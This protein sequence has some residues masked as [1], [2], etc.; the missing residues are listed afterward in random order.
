MKF[1]E[2]A[3]SDFQTDST[4]N[5]IRRK[6]ASGLPRLPQAT[7]QYL[8]QKVPIVQWLPQYHP[9]WLL[10]DFIAGMTIGVMMIPQA[11]AYA[12]IATIPGEFGLYSSWLPAAIYV[13][14]GTSKG[15]CGSCVR[16]SHCLTLTQISPP[17]QLPSWA[18]L[19]PRLSRTSRQKAL[20][21]KI[22]HRLSR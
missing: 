4:I 2:N 18:F 21:H 15:A 11:L 13:F 9:K 12:K 14:M 16:S 10:S 17:G 20:L 5:T 6:V 3:K 7:G 22:S 8:I 19:P 1:F